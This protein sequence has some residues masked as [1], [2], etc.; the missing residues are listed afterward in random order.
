M[1]KFDFTK[2]RSLDVF[3]SYD[4]SPL[5]GIVRFGET[6]QLKSCKGG[7]TPNHEGMLWN[8][9]GQMFVSQVGPR[10]VQ[11]DS[12]DTYESDKNYIIAVFRFKS[13]ADQSTFARAQE[14]MALWIRRWQNKKYDLWG[15]IRAS[16][17]MRKIAPWLK[18]DPNKPFC[19]ENTTEFFRQFGA[20][21]PLD[22]QKNPPNPLQAVRWC[23]D[24]PE[25]WE[26]ITGYYK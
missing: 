16:A 20:I 15:A 18:Q 6:G 23:R 19:S 2:L 26:E 25:Q 17:W 13:F 12:T 24:H 21:F 5:G 7:V 10:G 11:L 3:F 22:W 9:Y 4:H 8:L 1:R 14:Y